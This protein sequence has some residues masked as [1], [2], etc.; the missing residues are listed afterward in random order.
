MASRL[1]SGERF[2][3]KTQSHQ[4]IRAGGQCCCC[5]CWWTVP[6]IPPRYRS[7]SRSRSTCAVPGR[8]LAAEQPT[9]WQVDAGLHARSCNGTRSLLLRRAGIGTVHTWYL[10]SAA[11]RTAR[12]C[13]APHFT[14]LGQAR[15]IL[16][17]GLTPADSQHHHRHR[18]SSPHA[19]M[20]VS[21]IA[22]STHSSS[23]GRCRHQRTQHSPTRTQSLSH[24][25]I[26]HLS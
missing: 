17:A 13:T 10:Q 12:C 4:E 25:A 7:Y 8:K 22:S 18:H 20:D 6:H 21:S 2:S 14:R 16:G 23:I 9:V 5:C 26:L 24:T 15:S 3:H 19:H 1:K 11:Q